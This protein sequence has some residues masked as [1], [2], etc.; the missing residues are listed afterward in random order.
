MFEHSQYLT[1]EGLTQLE[2]RL[3][4]LKE[5]RRPEIAERCAVRWKKAAI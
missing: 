2:N 4:M 3:N 1:L 5:V